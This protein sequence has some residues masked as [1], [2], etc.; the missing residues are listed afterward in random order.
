MKISLSKNLR[1]LALVFAAAAALGGCQ[2]YEEP[3]EK[4]VQTSDAQGFQQQFPDLYNSF[5]KIESL[6]HSGRHL[7]AQMKDPAN[8][9]PTCVAN[10]VDGGAA[11]EFIP[12]LV[13]L[14]MRSGEVDA[15]AYT[16]EM[17]HAGQHI[18]GA[19]KLLGSPSLAIE[20]NMAG[21]MLVEASA[22]GYSFMVY[23]EMDKVEP[24]AYAN[25]TKT[26]YSFDMKPHFDAAYAKALPRGE[27]KALE[28]GGKAVVEALLRGVNEDWSHTYAVR[29]AENS[30]QSTLPEVRQ[31][32]GYSEARTEY[33]R[34]AGKVSPTVNITPD[35]MLQKNPE[36]GIT[37]H[38][39][40]SG[41]VITYKFN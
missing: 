9:I 38:L 28:A 4:C 29:S 7:A 40:K 12:E 36:Q 18:N 20:D 6:P 16:H 31:N 35:W 33:F 26:W 3:Y 1:K 32:A 15:R 22:V 8:A 13:K 23:K 21:N 37:T 39:A 34:Q 17:F 14:R 41:I 27:E 24:G 19:L 10:D 5:K 2:R 11:G 25:F 30:Y